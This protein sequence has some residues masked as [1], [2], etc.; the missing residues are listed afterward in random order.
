MTL[1]AIHY[2]RN[3]L[4]FQVCG[5]AFSLVAIIAI[6]STRKRHKIENKGSVMDG[7]EKIHTFNDDPL[8]LELLS[9]T[10]LTFAVSLSSF[11][12]G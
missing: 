3:I 7:P 11:M 10:I 1:V 2:K 12:T 9:N 5:N 4:L 8:I 6:R